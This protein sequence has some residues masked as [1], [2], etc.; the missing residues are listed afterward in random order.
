MKFQAPDNTT[1]ISIAGVELKAVDGVLEASE[2][3]A[4]LLGSHGFR[5]FGAAPFTISG[6]S[7]GALIN[8]LVAMA[9]AEAEAMSD[10][11]LADAVERMNARR[12][13][14]GER[15]AD[16][17]EDPNADR[18]DKMDKAELF[19]FLR[20]AGVSVPPALGLTKLREA[21][22]AAVASQQEA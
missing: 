12:L 19:D 15:Q 17:E 21:A 6:A 7:R 11:D 10:D 14:D 18:F 13:Q 8:A 4:E 2:A 16:G 20:S 5:P 9:R 3:H 1:S 22:R